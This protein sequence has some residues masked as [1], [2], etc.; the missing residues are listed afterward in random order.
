MYLTWRCKYLLAVL[1]RTGRGGGAMVLAAMMIAGG[2]PAT[3]ES[4]KK[5]LASAYLA[6]PT[7]RA[8][9]A[10][11]RSV[12]EEVPRARSGYRPSVSANIET[13]KER[14]KTVPASPGDGIN[15]PKTFSITATQ[16]IFRGFRT[17]NSEREADANVLAA[18]EDL[19][20][21]EQDI[22]TRA[23]T[24]YVDVVRDQAI[25]R[26]RQSNVRVLTKQLQATKDRLEVGEVT[27]TDLAQ[28][29]ARRARAVSAANLAQ[30]NLKSS[31]ATYQQLVGHA[32]SRLKQ[33]P[34]IERLLPRTITQAMSRG[35]S[36]NPRI[37]AAIY[38]EQASTHAVNR[39]RG[40]LLP[41]VTLEANY[42]RRL[43]PGRFTNE[44]E[45]A[46]IKLRGRIPLYQAGEVSARVR[47]ARQVDEQRQLLIREARRRVLADVVASWGRLASAKAQ[48]SSDRA[49]VE[50]SQT[51]LN[52]VREEEKVGQRTLLDVLDAE[53]E[54]LDAKVALV[55]TKRDYVVASYSLLGAT[56][57][58]TVAGL[59][60][61]VQIYDPQQ[62]YLEVR[63]KFYGFRVKDSTYYD[64]TGSYK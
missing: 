10:R 49:Q 31:R 63:R 44:Q 33:P 8:E 37:L 55:S 20:L 16:P 61:P 3:A 32:P 27:T 25:V 53:Q 64:G 40:E 38:R 4:L 12:D 46:S 48:I 5:A 47:Q 13:S 1:G 19:K 29:T 7:I 60:L 62:H 50:A 22:F 45:F 11:L 15:Y 28:A 54:L 36:E 56:G 24:A 35:E 21:V 39:I 6:N 43:N 23:V 17:I 57:R 52:G 18:R 9:R 34:S 42:Q 59:N 26:L 51:A 30:S 41:E 58:L 14:I 2:A